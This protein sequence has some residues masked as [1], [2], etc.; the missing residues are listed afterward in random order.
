[1][2]FNLLLLP[3]LGG[4]IFLRYWNPTRYHAIR[5]DKERLIILAAI[6]GF[7]SLV[8]AFSLM[9]FGQYLFPCKPN[10]FC[11]QTWWIRTVPFEYIGTAMSALLLAGLAWIPLNGLKKCDRDTAIDR[12]IEQDGVALDVLLKDAQSNA[13]AVS[14]TMSNGKF[15]IGFVIHIFNPAVPTKFIKILPMKSGYRDEVTKEFHFVNF[16]SRA[17]DDIDKDFEKKYAEWRVAYDQLEE[18]KKIQGQDNKALEL[19]VA[20]LDDQLEDLSL[21]AED[22]GIVLPVGE[23]QSVN[24]FSEYVYQS[25]FAPPKPPFLE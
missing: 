5:A 21:V 4:Y 10:H 7:I 6:P 14:V 8:I 25:Y 23:I 2:P 19:Y 22:F 15:Y 20:N 13:R 17:L 12:M 3:L 9:R 24:I 16:Y 11:F 1:M 18:A